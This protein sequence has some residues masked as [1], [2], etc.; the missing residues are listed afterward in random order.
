[1][2]AWLH[3]PSISSGVFQLPQSSTAL[4]IA[5]ISSSLCFVVQSRPTLQPHGTAALCR[6]DSAL[7]SFGGSSQPRHPTRAFCIVRWIPYHAAIRETHFFFSF[8]LPF[9]Q[10][11][12]PAPKSLSFLQGLRQHK[13][14]PAVT[15]LWVPETVRSLTSLFLTL[16]STDKSR[17]MIPS[18]V[19]ST[20][21]AKPPSKFCFASLTEFFRSE[22]SICFFVSFY[23]LAESFR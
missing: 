3:L 12:F 7:S 20:L 6:W 8:L 18:S 9:P 2:A 1:M 14:S 22:I 11:V 16:V 5:S 19:I 17:S 15:A 21:L 4:G 23:F 13:S 10:Q